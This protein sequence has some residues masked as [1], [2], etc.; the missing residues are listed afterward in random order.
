M[1]PRAKGMTPRAKGPFDLP[2]WTA[3]GIGAR[4]DLRV[5]AWPCVNELVTVKEAIARQRAAG[6][7]KGYEYADDEEALAD[8]IVV[9]WAWLVDREGGSI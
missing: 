5:Q 9:H 7:T 2:G 6:A 4:Y 1:T 3:E 8:F